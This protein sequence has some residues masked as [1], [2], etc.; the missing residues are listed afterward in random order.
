MITSF[1]NMDLKTEFSGLFKTTFDNAD[2]EANKRYL[3]VHGTDNSKM[4]LYRALHRFYAGLDNRIKINENYELR[5]D[6]Y[7]GRWVKYIPNVH[8]ITLTTPEDFEKKSLNDCW[9]RFS[10]R[11]KRENLWGAYY[12]VREWNKKGT[13][14]HIHVLFL[15][16]SQKDFE[17]YRESISYHWTCAVDGIRTSKKRIELS[18]RI[19]TRLERVY[20]VDGSLKGLANYLAKYLVKQT[21]NV[22]KYSEEY[23]TRFGRGMWYSHN[24]IFPGWNTYSKLIY[25]FGMGSIDFQKVRLMLAERGK[26]WLISS[27]IELWTK[28]RTRI[29]WSITFAR[30]LRYYGIIP[31]EWGMS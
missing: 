16:E 4:R 8:F 19:W 22:E 25:A 15:F 29:P 31:M 12:A 23:L 3:D 20:T 1:A 7:G 17:N 30:K 24:W 5:N 11:M 2:E 21:E 18:R 10:L 13:C 9:R 26:T 6:K 27:I 14:E 28:N